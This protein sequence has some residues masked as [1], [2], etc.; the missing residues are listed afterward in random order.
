M[1]TEIIFKDV[2]FRWF[3]EDDNSSRPVFAGLNLELPHGVVSLVGQNGTGKSTLLALA[4]GSIVPDEGQVLVRGV[5]TR[6]LRDERERQRHTSFVFQNM[7]FETEESIGELLAQ[8]HAA[9]FH[10]VKRPELL[11]E[12]ISVFELEPVLGRR[13]QEVSKGELQRT[14]LAFSLLYGSPILVM[15]EP[16]FALEDQQKR[17]ALGYL[18]EYARREGISLYFSL[19][20]LD[21]SREYSDWLLLFSRSEPPRLGPTAELFSR[22]TIERAY[23]VP[24]DM[25]KRREELYRRVLIE[26]LKV[27]PIPPTAAMPSGPS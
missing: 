3:D 26:A 23:E 2:S 16:I 24:F 1:E 20:E 12:L 21:L 15:D 13:T 7:E 9:G 17:R 14:I 27:R 22:D 18:R 4:A 10:A 6:R 25:L 11:G 19:H 8:V 5:D